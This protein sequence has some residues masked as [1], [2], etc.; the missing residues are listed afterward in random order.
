[1]GLTQLLCLLAA[2]ISLLFGQPILALLWGAFA[3]FTQGVANEIDSSQTTPEART[4]AGCG[5]LSGIAFLVLIVLVAALL[6]GVPLAG[7]TP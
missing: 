7:V 6:A 3:I 2:G 1:M 4:A 5:A